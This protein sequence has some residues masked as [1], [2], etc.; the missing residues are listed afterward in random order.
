MKSIY[1]LALL[2]FLSCTKE[3]QNISDCS[4]INTSFKTYNE[5]KNTIES[6]TF[7]FVDDV[8]TS[9]SSWIRSANYYS[10]DGKT[11]YFIYTTKKKKYIHE[12]LPLVVWD[13]FKNAESFGKFYNK[14]IKHRYR[15]ISDHE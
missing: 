5:A 13:D 14:H 4:E 1:I 8:D 10:C 11:G 7:K 3:R 2:I 9:R 6:I 12:N 15:L